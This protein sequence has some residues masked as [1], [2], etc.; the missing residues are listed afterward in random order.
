MKKVILFALVLIVAG[1]IAYV[2]KAE[3]IPVMS[4]DLTKEYSTDY[5]CMSDCM[6]RYMYGYCKKLCSY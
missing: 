6:K 5:T 4:S 1:S 3:S 2:K